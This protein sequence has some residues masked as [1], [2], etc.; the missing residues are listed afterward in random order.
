M[1]PPGASAIIDIGSNSIRLVVYSGSRRSPAIVFN[2]KVL[3]GLGSKLSETGR[4]SGK[5][6]GRALAALERFRLLIDQ[7]GVE[8]VRTVA[9]AAVREASNGAEFLKEVQRIGLKCDVL[10]AHEEARLAGE[11][12]LSAIPDADGIVGDLGGGSLEL[13][14]VGNGEVGTSLSLPLGILRIPD[15]SKGEALVAKALKNGLASSDLRKRAKGRTFYMVGGSWRALARLD[16][17]ATDYPL[18]IT[19]QYRMGPSRPKHLR[20]LA[21][22][23]AKMAKVIPTLSPDRVPTLPVAAMVLS[24]VTQELKPKSLVVSSLGIREGLLFSELTKRER[25]VDPLIAG[26]RD[27][28]IAVRRFEEHGDALDAWIDP[29]FN[30]APVLK[31]LRLASCILADAA[32]QAHPD[33]RAERGVDLAL[34]GNWAGA[35]ASARILMAQALYSNFGAQELLPDSRL[36]ELCRPQDVESA[37][38][39]GLA[40]RLGQRLCGGVAAALRGTSLRTDGARLVLQVPRRKAPL[41]GESVERRL[42]RL[43]QAM[44]LSAEVTVR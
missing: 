25:S 34:H 40:M 16:I 19:H 6:Q 22:D 37:Y 10:S 36:L 41:V 11:G 23:L 33:F 12:V 14:E 3:A 44:G 38:R 29:I 27:A 13:V 28:S 5:G 43:A 4:L 15:S 8:H 7:M 24:H 1:P 20:K 42:A 30:D 2:E 9:T 17:A 35:D 31:R 39:W 21:R 26:A 18:P 32:W